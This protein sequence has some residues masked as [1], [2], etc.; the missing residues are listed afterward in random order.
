MRR[1]TALGIMAAATAA[2]AAGQGLALA[3]EDA[4][5]QLTSLIKKDHE[6]VKKLF[7]QAAKSG[8][9]PA[10]RQ[11]LFQKLRLEL[12]P[13]M[14]GEEQSL[15][16]VMAQ[17]QAVREDALLG[18]EEH[19]AA[20]AIMMELVNMQPGDDRY[21]AKLKVLKESLEH[22]I[23][24]EENSILPKARKALSS[25]EMQQVLAGFQER[26]QQARQALQA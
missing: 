11:A 18:E 6:T 4:G 3:A 7:S 8:A 21:L 13:H 15:Y 22:H 23:E 26:K 9:A 5:S 14:Q 16:Q 1:R 17:K 10:D 19:H 25:Q 20:Q 24:E 2:V 12:L